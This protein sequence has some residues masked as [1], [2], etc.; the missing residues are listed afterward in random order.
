M[1]MAT[2]ADKLTEQVH[3]RPGLSDREL[4]DVL[5][6]R[7]KHPSQ[8]NQEARL[9]A[10]RGQLIRRQRPDGLIGNYPTGSAHV[11]LRDIEQPEI[12]Q[13][14]ERLSEDELKESLRRWLEKNGWSV[15]VAWRRT[16]G[17]DISAARS[18]SRWLIEVKGLGSLPAM[19]VNYFLMILG[20]TLQR[21]NDQGAKY[22]IALPDIPQFRGLWERLP[23]LAKERTTITALFVT[24]DG[25]VNEA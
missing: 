10:E 7:G 24:P 19:R 14:A 15:R 8:V 22:S 16:R 2:F 4:T 3:Q 6:G 20:E 25:R 11:Q 5:C 17:V 23:R 13:T 12:V 1:H 9:L 18:G 21:M